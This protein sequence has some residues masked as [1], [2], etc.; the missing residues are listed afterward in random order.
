MSWATPARRS[1]D[2][3]FAGS[4]LFRRQIAPVALTIHGTIVEWS[5]DVSLPYRPTAMRTPA[6]P[7][8]STTKELPL[9]FA[10]LKFDPEA[11]QLMIQ[12]ESVPAYPPIPMSLAQPVF[13][14]QVLIERVQMSPF[15][16]TTHGTLFDVTAMRTPVMV[17][18]TAQ[19]FDD[20]VQLS[21]LKSEPEAVVPIFQAP[22]LRFAAAMSF[23]LPET[24]SYWS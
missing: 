7:L 19:V 20:S 1:Q 18:S 21:T 8:A 23:A 11:S 3:V 22:E 13:W 9:H 16:L 10:T 14:T 17:E 24:D 5:V 2:P 15:A 4:E 12:M 6:P